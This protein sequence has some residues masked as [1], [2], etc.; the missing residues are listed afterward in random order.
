MDTLTNGICLWLWILNLV[1]GL[2]LPLSLERRLASF[3]SFAILHSD[4][5]MMGQ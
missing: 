2:H 5:F 1:V 4:P 3:F